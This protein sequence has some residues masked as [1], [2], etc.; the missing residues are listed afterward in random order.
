[1]LKIDTKLTC[2]D[3][4]RTAQTAMFKN[5][6]A[7]KMQPAMVINIDNNHKYQSMT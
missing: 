4:I 6:R 5:T 1:M 7:V 3:S 2:D